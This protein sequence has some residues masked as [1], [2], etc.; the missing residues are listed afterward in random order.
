MISNF[1]LIDEKLNENGEVKSSVRFREYK[2]FGMLLYK[3]EVYI[4]V[5][6]KIKKAL[7]YN[8]KAKK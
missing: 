7:G 8:I 6:K 3:K 1:E 2:I 5:S 4:N